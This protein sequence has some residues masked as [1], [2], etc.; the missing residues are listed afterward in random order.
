MP[1]IVVAGLWGVAGVLVKQI[2]DVRKDLNNHLPIEL[3]LILLSL[4][5]ASVIAFIV[6]AVLFSSKLVS[7]LPVENFIAGMYWEEGLD[8]LKKKY[9][10]DNTKE[11]SRDDKP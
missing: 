11:G 5:L 7:S 1:D 6:N 10:R 9:N 4:L 3:S 2:W 8:R